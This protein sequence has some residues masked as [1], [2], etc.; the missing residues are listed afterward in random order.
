M[1][2]TRSCASRNRLRRSPWALSNNSATGT[3]RMAARLTT[4]PTVVGRP[5]KL[6]DGTTANE[7][8]RLKLYEVSLVP[9]GANQDTSVLAVKAPRGTRHDL[10]LRLRLARA[11]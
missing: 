2:L 5:V 7:L 11:G 8:R 9:V 4:S 1:R 10:E 3:R 6:D